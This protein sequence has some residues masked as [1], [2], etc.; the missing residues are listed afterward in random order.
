MPKKDD[1]RK[2]WETTDI[3]ADTATKG[4]HSVVLTLRDIKP[5]AEILTDVFGYRLLEQEGN[6]YRF[7]TD[8]IETA[9]IIDL[10]ELPDGVPGI[11]AA[12][13]N[14]HIAFSCKG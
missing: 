1:N 12:G 11:S 7:I 9:A 3:K 10:I 5:T 2:A 13:T 6:R 4:F 14:H 8:T